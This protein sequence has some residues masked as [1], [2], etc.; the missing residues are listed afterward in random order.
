MS[1]TYIIQIPITTN[2]DPSVLL[3]LAIEASEQVAE[4]AANCVDGDEAT[5]DEQEILVRPAGLT[6]LERELLDAPQLM[7]AY[8]ALNT[9]GCISDEEGKHADILI[10]PYGEHNTVPA[11]LDRA[12]AVIAKTK[13]QGGAK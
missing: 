10:H 3:D 4:E 9:D 2:C 12:R 11:A 7:T 1:Q 6:T 5:V 8:T 13:T